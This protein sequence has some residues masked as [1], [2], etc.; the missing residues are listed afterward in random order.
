MK[1]Y[2]VRK[3]TIGIFFYLI[4]LIIILLIINVASIGILD[5]I[6]RTITF[7]ESRHANTNAQADK[8]IL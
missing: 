1:Y 6:Q 5:N 8:L 3:K 4:A 2:S 7:V